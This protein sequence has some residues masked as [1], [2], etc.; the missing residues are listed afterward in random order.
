MA[1]G[2]EY[3][4]TK[5]D[6]TD[7][8]TKGMV[9]QVHKV[10]EEVAATLG[11][12]VYRA[13]IINNPS[14][15]TVAGKVY[16][17]VLVG[18]PDD[19]AVKGKVYNA[20]LTGGSE[21]VIVGPGVSPLSLPDAVAEAIDSL[22]AYGGTEQRNLPVEYTQLDYI[23]SSGTQY[24]NTGV[25]VKA[26]TRVRAEFEF[27]SSTS[28][29]RRL[30]GKI[31]GA[32][33]G[34]INYREYASFYW[35]QSNTITTTSTGKHLIEF[36][37]D[38]NVYLDGVVIGTKGTFATGNDLPMYLFAELS[39]GGNINYGSVKVYRF[40]I[41]EDTTI[42]QNLV[43]CKRKSDNVLG[44]YDTVNGVFYENAGTGDFVAGSTM[45]PTPSYP[46]DIIC[47]NG[48][49]KYSTNMANINAQTALVGY[50]ISSTGVVTADA[51]NWIYQ[52][53]IPVKPNTTYT[54][55]FDISVY[56]VTIS[57]YSTA[58]DSGFIVRKAGASGTNTSLTITTGADT[59]YVRFG[60]NIDRSAVTLEEVLGIKWQLN[61]G[62]NIMPYQPYVDGGVYTA[63]PIETIAIKDDQSATV[64]TATCEDLLSVGTYTDEQEVVSGAVTRKVGVLVLD[65]VTTGKKIGTAWNTTYKRGSFAVSDMKSTASGV[66]DAISTHFEYAPAVY[67]APTVAGFC[68]NG[69][70]VFICFL[71]LDSVTSAETANDW[72]ATQYAA[73][74][75]VMVVYPLKTETTETVTGQPMQT[76]AGDNT[77]EITQASIDGL[78]LE[79]TYEKEAE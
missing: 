71:G 7:P 22:I 3:Q 59:N 31:A 55:S 13:R 29:T 49:L 14:D 37:T 39:D 53:Y 15:T 9:Y 58:D 57:E 63:G 40:T 66:S 18:D 50:Y 78:Q 48:V 33:T 4:V 45:A 54:L 8:E 11:G 61:I 38:G 75:P 26:N 20:I 42:V 25:S 28:S 69:G 56:Y 12:K 73:G 47:N 74:T 41:F 32:S 1:G 21:A 52:D 16:Q 36:K 10:S 68:T 60:T 2:V 70:S 44:M 19:P 24:V 62:S 17:I 72:L 51:N 79:V 67:G 5:V 76:A 23:E 77:A 27:T 34:A 65:G 64:S 43:P 46:M 35:F 6:P 30:F